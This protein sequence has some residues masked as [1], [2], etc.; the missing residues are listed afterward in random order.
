MADCQAER[1]RDM[2]NKKLSLSIVSHGN[3]DAVACLLADLARLGRP[4]LEVLLTLNLPESLAVDIEALPF[5]VTLI[6]NAGPKGFAANH[7]AA[8][9]LSRGDYFVLLNP[10]I[11]LPDDPF[12]ILLALAAAAPD[13]IFAPLV[14]NAAHEVEDSARNFPTP[15]FLLKKLVRKLLRFSPVRE[16]IPGKDDVLMPDWVA[17]MFVMLPRGLY[18]KLRGLNERY[19]LYYEDVDL[20]ARARLAGCAILVSRRAKVVHEA[21]RASHRK[22]RYLLWHLQSACRFFTSAAY[23]RIQMRRLFQG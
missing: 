11:R 5:E 4:D 9:A 16:G 10:D 21:Q 2:P 22:L 14:L 19:H 1:P 8:F 20:C 23:L 12:D 3:R 15:F 6:R 7:N 13:S 17:G 18:E